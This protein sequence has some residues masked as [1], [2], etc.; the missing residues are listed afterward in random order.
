MDIRD[1]FLGLSTI[2]ESNPEAQIYVGSEAVRDDIINYAN[3]ATSK[4][5]MDKERSMKTKS[6]RNPGGFDYKKINIISG[7]RLDIGSGNYLLIESINE[8]AECRHNTVL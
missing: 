6:P 7:N 4:G 8:P 1:H 5:L 3:L 2:L